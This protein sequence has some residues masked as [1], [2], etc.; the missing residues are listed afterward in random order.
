MEALEGRGVLRRYGMVEN[1]RTI[2]QFDTTR[3]FLS[4]RSTSPIDQQPFSSRLCH[5]LTP[6]LACTFAGAWFL[7]SDRSIGRHCTK[8]V[9]PGTSLK[10]RIFAVACGCQRTASFR[11]RR[12]GEVR[13]FSRADRRT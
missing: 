4:K 12:L 2:E 11:E 10:R 3:V 1:A 6:K 5:P 13:R 7:A 9:P 8:I